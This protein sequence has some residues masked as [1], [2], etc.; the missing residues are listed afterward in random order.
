MM[1]EFTVKRTTWILRWCPIGPVS[2]GYKIVILAWEA[3][4]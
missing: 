4:G 1:T 2:Q 3:E